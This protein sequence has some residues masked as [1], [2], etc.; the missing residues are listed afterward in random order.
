MPGA[1]QLTAPA[2]T[3]ARHG[4]PG[5]SRPG[6]VLDNR[7]SYTGFGLAWLA[8]HGAFAL[9]H[10]DEPLLALPSAV[11]AVVLLTGLV[12]AVAVTAA[13]N[14]RDQ[15]GADR[16]AALAGRLLGASWAIGF[17]A[18]FLMI[19]ALG[20]VLDERH[21]HTVLWPTG[22]GLVVGL[23]LLAGGAVHRDLSQYALGAW[24]ALT[25]S[26]ALFLDVPNLYWVLAIAGGGGYLVAAALEP[27]RR[28]AALAA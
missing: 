14:A 19:T 21:V 25:S 28:A 10:G 18:L 8:G 17:A 27:R 2:R 13:T 1:D 16:D 15:K 20:G 26:A 24:L 12:A 11:P 6:T 7:A 4:L 9:A 3:P 22:S 5:P 23:L